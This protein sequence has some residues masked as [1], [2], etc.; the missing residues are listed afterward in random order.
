VARI[1][2]VWDFSELMTTRYSRESSNSR[3]S[4]FPR[5]NPSF[6]GIV[7]QATV[8]LQ[9]EE[10]ELPLGEPQVFTPQAG[11]ENV[12]RITLPTAMVEQA[13]E[14]IDNY[15]RALRERP[16][17]APRPRDPR[18]SEFERRLRERNRSRFDPRAAGFGRD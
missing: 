11:D 1:A 17:E 9:S 13:R 10:G 15:Q 7:S 8:N 2:L 4:G 16:V 14:R 12:W 18:V 5:P 3:D 6:V